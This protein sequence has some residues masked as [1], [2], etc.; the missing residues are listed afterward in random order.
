M[1]SRTDSRRSRLIPKRRHASGAIS[2]LPVPLGAGIGAAVRVAAVGAVAAEA[3]VVAA[4]AEAVGTAEPGTV[5]EADEAG[6]AVDSEAAVSVADEEA[7]GTYSWSARKGKRKGGIKMAIKALGIVLGL[8]LIMA[9]C[10]QEQWKPEVNYAYNVDNGMMY[11]RWNCLSQPPG[12]V[13]QGFVNNI[14]MVAMKNTQVTIS[15]IDA[16][17]ATVSSVQYTS[18]PYMLET[19]IRTP[20]EMR[21]K[22]TGTEVRYD[23]S[24]S[25]AMGMDFS[26]NPNFKMDACPNMDR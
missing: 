4:P 7:Q 25:Y 17:G 21:L 19:M 22:T 13:V 5:V 16:Q 23:L 14:T 20:F 26:Q 9:A 12:L 15:G 11:L 6:V 8:S 1:T 24:Y 3:G 2:G 18:F 10:A